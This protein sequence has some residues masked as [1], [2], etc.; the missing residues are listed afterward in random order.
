MPFSGLFMAALKSNIPWAR[1]VRMGVTTVVMLL[2]SL[3]KAG[4]GGAEDEVR[5]ATQAD[6]DRLLGNA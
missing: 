6:I 4:G 2:D 1:L 5:D 3:P